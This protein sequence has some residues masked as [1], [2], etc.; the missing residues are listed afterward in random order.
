MPAPIPPV[1]KALDR[2]L[3][4]RQPSQ[5]LFPWNIEKWLPVVADAKD[6]Q[7]VLRELPPELGREEVRSV[8]QEQLAAERAI[9]A[10][11]PVMIWGGP[12]GYGPFRTRAILTGNRTAENKSA[13]IDREVAPRLVEAARVV[14][15]VGPVAA[16]RLLNNTGHI[17][18]L[19][20]AFF[21]KWMS[22]A[23]AVTSADAE[24]VAPI[25][26]KRVRDWIESHT[27]DTVPISLSTSSTDDYARYLDLLDAWRTGTDWSKTRVQV[28]LAIFELARDRP[29]M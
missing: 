23:S 2:R 13:P 25:L 12:R 19:G 14:R 21:T 5:R 10:F 20:G 28:E 4:E 11:V 3:A 1:P 27:G 8:V 22:F 26:D 29:A 24:G 16:F 17:K 9:A 6:A 7:A 15:E 18:Y